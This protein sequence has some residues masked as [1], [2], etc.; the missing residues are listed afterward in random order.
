MK[1]TH[2]RGTTFS[3][4]LFLWDVYSF[5]ALL[6]SSASFCLLCEV[7]AQNAFY[8]IMSPLSI[9]SNWWSSSSDA[10]QIA[11]LSIWRKKRNQNFEKMVHTVQEKLL[12]KCRKNVGII[13]NR[14]QCWSWGSQFPPFKRE[15][16]KASLLFISFSVSQKYAFTQL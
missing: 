13:E 15:Y 9:N 14:C 3:L 2:P 4:W 16:P 11:P 1:C 7:L 5:P 6:I 10:S 12:E 8:L